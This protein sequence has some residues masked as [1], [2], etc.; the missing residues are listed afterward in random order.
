MSSSISTTNNVLLA[1]H[2][3]EGSTGSSAIT[4]DPA[5]IN[6]AST[7]VRTVLWRVVLQTCSGKLYLHPVS[8]SITS[9]GGEALRKLRLEYHRALSFRPF[10]CWDKTPIFFSPVIETAILS[11]VSLTDNL[12]SPTSY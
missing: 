10:H 3:I 2:V 4:M 11:V 1:G 5:V 9:N 6:P 8:L 7:P 12:L